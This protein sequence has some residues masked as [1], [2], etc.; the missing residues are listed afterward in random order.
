MRRVVALG[1]CESRDGEGDEVLAI[2]YDNMVCSQFEKCVLL[3]PS[4]QLL[5]V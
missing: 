5:T 1:W 3:G 4:S 2:V